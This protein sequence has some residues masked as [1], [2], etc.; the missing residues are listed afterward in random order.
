MSFNVCATSAPLFADR[1]VFSMH[2]N[3]RSVWAATASE[4]GAGFLLKNSSNAWMCTIRLRRAI[5]P[6]GEGTNT[7]NDYLNK[8]GCTHLEIPW[9]EGKCGNIR[10]RRLANVASKKCD[11]NITCL[12]TFVP[13]RQAAATFAIEV[14]QILPAPGDLAHLAK[15]LSSPT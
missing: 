15:S 13:S 10:E 6:I 11:R 14:S 12:P 8:H 1:C 3:T 4:L 5:L 2:S 7:L 9:H